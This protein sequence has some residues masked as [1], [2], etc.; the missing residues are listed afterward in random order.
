M[1]ILCP[2]ARTRRSELVFIRSQVGDCGYELPGAV[3]KVL[4]VLL[5]PIVS[6][7]AH[8]QLGRRVAARSQV[9]MPLRRLSRRFKSLPTH[10][11]EGGLFVASQSHA[12]H[13]CRTAAPV[14]SDACVRRRRV[15]SIL[16]ILCLA[17][18]LMCP[19][20]S[21]KQPTAKTANSPRGPQESPAVQQPARPPGPW[22]G[23]RPRPPPCDLWGC[24]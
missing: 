18:T 5:L 13:W 19:S 8:Q 22:P 23:P 15:S 6:L 16:W 1:R 3:N 17:C 20:L 24:T 12:C 4:K 10:S 21:P 7:Y 9:R 14:L 11:M 2:A